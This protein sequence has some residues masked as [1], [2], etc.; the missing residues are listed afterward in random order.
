MCRMTQG[1][2]LKTANRLE[3]NYKLPRGSLDFPRIT[4]T[5]LDAQPLMLLSESE[6][7]WPQ[8][9]EAAKQ[10]FIFM[11]FDERFLI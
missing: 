10:W 5:G 11:T 9:M 8:H 2:G 7:K 1:S 3:R 4:A 6:K